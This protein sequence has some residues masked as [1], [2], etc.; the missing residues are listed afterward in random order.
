MYHLLP[1]SVNGENIQNLLFWFA[2]KLLTVPP[3]IHTVEQA[4][5]LIPLFNHVVLSVDQSLAHHPLPRLWELLCYSVFPWQQ[6]FQIPQ[7]SEIMCHKHNGMLFGH[8]RW[9]LSYVVA[10]MYLGNSMLFT[11]LT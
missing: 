11:I 6:L 3:P 10:C 5:K 2:S 9:T 7:M 8:R 1:T 4:S